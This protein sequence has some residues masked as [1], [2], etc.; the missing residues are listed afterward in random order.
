MLGAMILKKSDNIRAL[1]ST[2][3][4]TKPRSVIKKKRLISTGM[5]AES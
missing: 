3:V 2:T 1:L 5:R 4:A